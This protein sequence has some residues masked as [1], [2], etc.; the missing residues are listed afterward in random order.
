MTIKLK[1]RPKISF[2]CVSFNHFVVTTGKIL[3]LKLNHIFIDL[4]CVLR[5]VT[6]LRLMLP[7]GKGMKTT[8]AYK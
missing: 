8:S 6:T 4:S 3:Y 1:F 5:R 7:N 2:L